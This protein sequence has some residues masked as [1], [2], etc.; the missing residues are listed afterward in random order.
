[1]SRMRSGGGRTDGADAKRWNFFDASLATNNT[2]PSMSSFFKV[3]PKQKKED[4]KHNVDPAL[5]P[6]IEK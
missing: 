4:A 5:Q 2:T 1:M 3:P 6:W